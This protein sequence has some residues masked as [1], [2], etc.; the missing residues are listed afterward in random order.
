MFFLLIILTIITPLFFTELEQAEAKPDKINPDAYSRNSGNINKDIYQ[1]D[2]LTKSKLAG[3][4]F[5]DRYIHEGQRSGGYTCWAYNASG[6][7]FQAASMLRHPF[8]GTLGKGNEAYGE[9]RNLR[10]CE[11]GEKLIEYEVH[12]SDNISN[13]SYNPSMSY[14]TV[15]GKKSNYLRF[16]GWSTLGGFTHH[17]GWNQSTYVAAVEQ[18]NGKNTTSSSGVHI[19]KTV[20]NSTNLTNHLQY[21]GMP[22]CSSS[23][24]TTGKYIYEQGKEYNRFRGSLWYTY[25]NSNYVVPN[26]KSVL[27]FYWDAGTGQA[28]EWDGAELIRHYQANERWY[29]L[30]WDPYE[31]KSKKF[32][33]HGMGCNFNYPYAGFTAYLNMDDMLGNGESGKEF[34]VYLIK[35]IEDMIVAT[36]MQMPKYTES[37]D[38]KHGTVS[39]K[40]YDDSDTVRPNRTGMA[41]F[42]GYDPNTW[43][44]TKDL[45]KGNFDKTLDYKLTNVYVKEGYPSI[46]RVINPKN[47]L[48]YYHYA[49]YFDFNQAEKGSTLSYKLEGKNVLVRHLDFFSCPTSVRNNISGNLNKDLRASGCV[50]VKEKSTGA[51][52]LKGQKKYSKNFYTQWF[53]DYTGSEVYRVSKTKDKFQSITPD[54]TV[55]LSGG[56]NA[57]VN[58]FYIDQNQLGSLTINYID[59]QTGKTLRAQNKTER[60]KIGDTATYSVPNSIAANGRTYYVMNSPATSIK[61]TG[62]NVVNLK[63]NPNPNVDFEYIDR[64][65]GKKIGGTSYHHQRGTNFSKTPPSSTTS[66][67]KTYYREESGAITFSSLWLDKTVKIYYTNQKDVTVRHYDFYSC[68][69]SEATHM[70]GDL[71]E[72]NAGCLLLRERD[73]GNY[74]LKGSGKYETDMEHRF[75]KY[76]NSAN[77][78]YRGSRA[79]DHYYAENG[80]S[81]VVHLKGTNKT[82]INFFYKNM[83]DEVELTVKYV[84]RQSGKTLKADYNKKKIEKGTTVTY[85]M[86]DA[87]SDGTRP[88]YRYGNQSGKVLMSA[89][90]VIT[91]QYNYNPDVTVKKVDRDTGKLLGT[92]TKRITGGTTHNYTPE[93]KIISDGSSFYREDSGVVSFPTLWKDTTKTVYYSKYKDV[94]VR[95]YDFYSCDL[96][97]AT[98]MIGDLN[99]LGAGCLLLKEKNTGKSALVGSGR[100]ETDMEHR[101]WKYSNTADNLFRHDRVNDS[102]YAEN[103]S[104]QVVKLSGKEKTYINFFYKNRL[105]EVGLTVKYVDRQ[106]GDQLQANYNNKNIEKGTTFEYPMP[107]MLLKDGRTYYR[108]GNQTGRVVMTESKVVTVQ[109]NYN[110]K[111]TIK[112]VDKETNKLLNTEE[113]LVNRGENF[114]VTPPEM[115]NYSS[116]VGGTYY[117][118]DSGAISYKDL[119]K[120]T[121]KTVYYTNKKEIDMGHYDLNSCPISIRG[122]SV[123]IPPYEGVELPVYHSKRYDNLNKSGCESLKDSSTNKVAEKGSGKYTTHQNVTIQPYRTAD[124]DLSNLYLTNKADKYIQA[125]YSYL[126]SSYLKGIN[127]EHF[128]YFYYKEEDVANLKVEYIDASTN[129]K[130]KEDFIYNKIFKGATVDYPMQNSIAS[131]I[132]GKSKTY[133]LRSDKNVGLNGSIL[134]N[135][136]KTIK[137]YYNSNPD[138]TTNY[139]DRETGKVFK[140][141]KYHHHRGTDFTTTTETGVMNEGNMHYR[142]GG[143]VTL[144]SVWNDTTINVEY[145]DMRDVV[146]RHFDGYEKWKNNKDVELKKRKNNQALGS[147]MYK[148]NT[149]HVF[150]AYPNDVYKYSTSD[151]MVVDGESVQHHTPNLSYALLNSGT[152]YYVSFYYKSSVDTTDVFIGYEESNTKERL[153]KTEIL[154]D[155]YIGEE[156]DVRD[157]SKGGRVSVNGRNY[158][159]H[160][161]SPGGINM[162][163]YK[164]QKSSIYSEERPHIVFGYNKRPIVTTRYIN[165]ETGAVIKSNKD[166]VDYGGRHQFTNPETIKEGGVTYTAYDTP[167]LHYN[168]NIRKDIVINLMYTDKTIKERPLEYQIKKGATEGKT[169][170]ENLSW[171]MDEDNIY[172]KTDVRPSGKHAA[173]VNVKARE[174]YSDKANY[175]SV[176]TY[177]GGRN[178][179]GFKSEHT[180]LLETSEDGLSMDSG[181]YSNY[182][183]EETIKKDARNV[184]G[185]HVLEFD[186]DYTNLEM[187]PFKCVD[188]K[189]TRC[190]EWAEDT[191]AMYMPAF[192]EGSVEFAYDMVGG[193]A[194]NMRYEVIDPDIVVT[195]RDENGKKVKVKAVGQYRLRVELDNNSVVGKE[196][197]N[198]YEI[199]PS[200]PFD[201]SFEI[202]REFVWDDSVEG[203]KKVTSGTYKEEDDTIKSL[204]ESIEIKPEFTL[205]H[206]TQGGVFFEESIKYKNYFDE[207]FTDTSFTGNYYAKLDENLS[208]DLPTSDGKSEI[209]IRYDSSTEE[210]KLDKVFGLSKKYGLQLVVDYTEYQEDNG[211]LN[212][213]LVSELDELDLTVDKL[214]ELDYGKTSRYFMPI[215]DVEDVKGNEVLDRVVLKDLGY[216][217]LKVKY[218]RKI[219]YTDYLYGNIMDDPIYATQKEAPKKIEDYTHSETLDSETLDTIK[220][221]NAIE[222]GEKL[223]L[224]RASDDVGIAEW[225]NED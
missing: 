28:T 107:E 24:A 30:Y 15:S 223:N 210:F 67:G 176:P 135:G 13:K 193:V 56:G 157:Y 114:S 37:K 46:Y 3:N 48:P 147:G 140:T 127:T 122:D 218:D 183:N 126:H 5:S 108:Y 159:L 189:N 170:I 111:V 86:P 72:L 12:A 125:P 42:R 201:K 74:A 18:V 70:L 205:E 199:K 212:D 81:Q 169:D 191:S 82:Y 23:S 161:I 99:P 57:Y 98:H 184:K 19:T 49:H 65:T 2:Y 146:V 164:V 61:I 118:L 131:S 200:E 6:Y 84:D 213:E 10:Q 47:N 171:R 209:G 8:G 202:G 221:Y 182:K 181:V 68:A 130:L 144:R 32:A 143:E 196:D 208:D 158:D 203:G 217:D 149:S 71:N 40:G 206:N 73:T 92:Y 88:F 162:T 222:R 152:P 173:V 165:E 77:G 31:S 21:G 148:S 53:Y 59:N 83:L 216:N 215:D 60:L 105:D 150:N 51:V 52:A 179:E 109:Y 133:Y 153:F 154:K 94:T 4:L 97:E 102:Y 129:K 137:V 117:R 160:F 7:E 132:S 177:T 96:S 204:T 39:F 194:T 142:I 58:F 188:G 156:L 185:K 44:L 9:T 101:F 27:S 166:E 214:V 207:D 168:L 34:K 76:A 116:S 124:G 192:V 64:T 55:Y 167:K 90:K 190:F 115:Y 211:I 121:T 186:Y 155:K 224:Y 106:T 91:V 89:D 110:P 1:V 43:L 197:S 14:A 36:E 139:V 178:K 25:N 16:T 151:K 63:Y 11:D 79:N 198:Q 93:S 35:R 75:Y 22:K 225:L 69:L 112:Y 119:W 172:T 138:I 174:F 33:V 113:Y 80:S 120:D 136:D 134:M 220:G 20:G 66:G 195:A 103:S 175:E 26:Q 78:L 180:E 38:I 45:E 17:T 123:G 141:T 50:S 104:S 100:Y 62:N 145:T 87:I 41:T 163:K 29:K 54:R 85:P 187:I 219:E 95:H 128:N